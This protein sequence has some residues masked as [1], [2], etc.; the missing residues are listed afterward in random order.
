[1]RIFVPVPMAPVAFRI[2]VVASANDP[3]ESLAHAKHCGIAWG[4]SFV[5]IGQAG[6]INADSGHGEWNEGYAI[7][8]QL[9]G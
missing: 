3:L 5:D 1:M 8:Q 2:L 9:A 6:Y 4:S 7:F